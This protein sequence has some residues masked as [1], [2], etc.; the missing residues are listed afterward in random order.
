MVKRAKGRGP[1]QRA[2][3]KGRRAKGRGQSARIGHAFKARTPQTNM[4]ARFSVEKEVLLKHPSNEI[5][6]VQ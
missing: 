2:K 1:G 3:G 5:F 4:L 6:S